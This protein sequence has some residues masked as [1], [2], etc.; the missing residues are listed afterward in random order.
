MTLDLNGVQETLRANLFSVV[1]VD[2]K[3]N[4]SFQNRPFT[5]PEDGIWI[6]EHMQPVEEVLS[7]S[8]LETTVGNYGIDVFCRIGK[9]T[10]QVEEMVRLLK[11]AFAP[12][13]SLR[14]GTDG[15]SVSI[16][17]SPR[18]NARTTPGMNPVWWFRPMVVYWRAFSPRA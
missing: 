6:R 12:G 14:R 13:T 17:R 8:G 18:L 4:V 10:R 16:Y 5:P 2:P 7:S 11:A 9:G 3:T 1:G 15:V